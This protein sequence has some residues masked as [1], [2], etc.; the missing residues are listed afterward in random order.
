[1]DGG[2]VGVRPS[3]NDSLHQASRHEVSSAQLHSGEAAE[4]GDIAGKGAIARIRALPSMQASY[5]VVLK[6]I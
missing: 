4:N 1:M 5:M 6:A 3:Y 2:N